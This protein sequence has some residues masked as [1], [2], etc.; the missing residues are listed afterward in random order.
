MVEPPAVEVPLIEAADVRSAA[1][2]PAARPT[3]PARRRK[4]APEPA[5]A[6]PVARVCVDVPLA[7]L[8]RPFDYLVPAELD[9]QAQPGVRVRVRFAGQLVDGFVLE[10]VEASRRTPAGWRPCDA[11]CRPSR[12]CTR[13]SPGSPGPSPTGTPARS[14]TCCGWPC[15]RG[16]PGP[17]RHPAAAPPST[18]RTVQPSL[19]RVDGRVPGRRRASC[20]RV[21]AGKPAARGVD[22][23][24]GRGLAGPVRRSGRRRRRRGPGALVVVVADARD[25]DRLDAALTARTRRRPACAR[26]R[27]T[28][29]PA[30]R[31]RAFLARPLARRARSPGRCV[32]T[33]AGRPFAP[34]A[35]L[36]LVAIWDDGDDLHAEPRAPY[37]HAREVL[38]TARPARRVRRCWSAGTRAPP[39]RSSSSR[40]AGPGSSSRPGT[41]CGPAAPRVQPVGDDA[42]RARDPAAAAARLPSL[43]WRAARDALAAGAPV[44]VQVPRAGLP[45]RRSPAPSCR[46][47]ARCPACAGPLRAAHGRTGA[48]GLPAGAAGLAGRVRLPAL[49]RP[50]TAG[51]R[52]R[53]RADRRGARPGLPGSAGA[54]VRPGRRAA[55][56]AGDGPRWSCRHAGRRAVRP[57]AGTAPRC[58]ST[59][60][61]CWP[62]PTCGRARRRC[63]GG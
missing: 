48:A 42:Q 11:S 10:R 46:T 40:P 23:A 16:T 15:R 35:D 14:P 18:P 34:V 44:L 12:C 32:G 59:P 21:G 61:P 45:A 60:G 54:H 2:G 58:C 20:A 62:G 29:G 22:G 17:R 7:H 6:L 30:E 49:R 39:R 27:P 57:R 31:Y 55:D 5:V 24:A 52:G 43:A 47:P 56:R 38:C 53:R 33:R 51:R 4:P 36:G 19:D 28:S 50:A 9:G 26:C 41:R 37:P 63:A 25:L 8:D 13:R 1:T 3:R